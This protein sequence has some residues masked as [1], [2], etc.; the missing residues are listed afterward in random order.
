MKVVRISEFGGPEVLEVADL[1]DP[2]PVDGE[3]LVRAHA[4]GVAKPDMLMRSGRYRWAPP[5]P[6]VIGN[7]MSGVVE[8]VGP[9]VDDLK[10]GQ[11]VLVWGFE[12][13]CYTELGVYPRRRIQPLPDGV[14]LDAAVAIPNHLVAWAL[15]HKLTPRP[16]RIVYVNGAAGGVGTAVIQVCRASGIEV[17]AGASSREKCAFTRR[18]GAG[19][20]IDYGAEDVVE[21]L[22]EL[23]GGH[24]VD[25]ILD[26]LVGPAFTENLKALATLGTI[27]S[28]NA[29]KGLPEQELFAAMR[30]LLAKS[31]GVRCF[32]FHS[33]DHDPQARN[34]LMDKVLPLFADRTLDPPIHARLPLAEARKAHELL[35][36]GAIMG[37][38]VLKP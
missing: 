23:T 30:G 12:Q 6:A 20:A 35:D 24:G 32:S 36:A 8:A 11:P 37:K 28:F 31:P 1:D 3:V 18:T 34:R 26:Q 38:L 21:R 25:L 5:L 14:D 22:L 15:V 29:L 9:G 17:I 10:P 2:A 33:Y 19:E 13:G 16:P 7:E 27:V 4:I